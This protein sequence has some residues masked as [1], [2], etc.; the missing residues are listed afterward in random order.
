MA[1]YTYVKNKRADDFTSRVVFSTGKDMVIGEQV[2]LT[3]G[4]VTEL[5]KVASLL[6][7]QLGSVAVTI[8]KT[9]FP[10]VQRYVRLGT[11][12]TVIHH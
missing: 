8:D 10:P 6:D 7:I 1:I 3:A 4:E 11:A 12:L 5:A 9:N 2:D